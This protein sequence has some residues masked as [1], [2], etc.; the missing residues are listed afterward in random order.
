MNGKKKV[1]VIKF[2]SQ[3]KRYG[4]IT[5]PDGS[6][7]FFHLSHFRSLST[8]VPGNVVEFL[9]GQNEEGPTAEE[10]IVVPHSYVTYYTGVITQLTFE[11]GVIE[12]DDG[13][14]RVNF[15]RRDFIPH[16]QAHHLSEGD[17]VAM[18]FLVEEEE[19]LRAAVVRPVD[20]D[21][22][23]VTTAYAG[24]RETEDEQ[25]NR[26]LLGILYRTDLDAEAVQTARTLCGRN[27]R[28]TLSALAAR[29][30]D[31][32]LALETRRLL[33]QCIPDIYLDEEGQEFLRE[34]SACL[35]R[36]VEAE[37]QSA[38]QE[39]RTLLG[40]FSSETFFPLKWSQYLLPYSLTILQRL[41]E[42]EDF[43]MLLQQAAIEKDRVLRL[44]ERACK[45]VGEHRTGFSYVLTTLLTAFG[46]LWNAGLCQAAV[47]EYTSRV[48]QAVDGE[49]LTQQLH[50]L[51]DRLHPPY[52]EHLLNV[53]AAHPEL[54]DA[55][56]DE[57]VSSVL[58]EWLEALR[59]RAEGEGRPL[60]EIL[61]GLL[62]ILERLCQFTALRD[63]LERLTKPFWEALTPRE[64]AHLMDTSQFPDEAVWACLRHFDRRGELPALAAEFTLRP[65]LVAWLGRVFPRPT[66]D[67]RRQ[68]E[69][70]LAFRLVDQLRP[71]EDVQPQLK[72]VVELIFADLKVQLETAPSEALPDL[73]ARLEGLAL[74]GL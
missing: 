60:T 1:G 55:L 24:R 38:P 63:T 27:L 66:E 45:H 46:A 25:E 12:R 17:R 69:T 21:P 15:L 19:G 54:P 36:L 70:H 10:V 6:D 64:L 13:Q 22:Y 28:A 18:C 37:P 26:R 30:L 2:Y 48:L 53:L 7:V 5:R 4:F 47:Q 33:V 74:P 32:S 43:P 67:L 50:F 16:Y 34:T 52:I 23:A 44:L 41:T 14:G 61:L 29:A 40:W 58:M 72:E 11:G 8:P 3:R 59:R 51:R 20:Y 68:L 49:E 31:P 35:L 57:T 62:P 42:R 9:E 73:L 39:V 65:H 56:A 71:Y